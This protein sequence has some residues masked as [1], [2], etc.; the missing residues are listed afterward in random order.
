M[1]TRSRTR[2]KVISIGNSQGVRIPKPLLELTGLGGDVELEVDRDRIIIRPASRPR[3][4]WDE[5]FRGMAEK[6]HD[7]PVDDDLTGASP[8]DQQEWEW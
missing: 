8:W 6:G 1:E 3:Q 4:G 5:A 2:T 7:R